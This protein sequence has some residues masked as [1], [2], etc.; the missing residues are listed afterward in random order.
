MAFPMLLAAALAAGQ[1]PSP[2]SGVYPSAYTHSGRFPPGF[3]WAVGS[4]AYQI[5]GGQTD[6]RGLSICA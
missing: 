4:A 6:G 2:Y 5:E 1:I 3:L